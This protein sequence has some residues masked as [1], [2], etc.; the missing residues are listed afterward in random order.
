M[1]ALTALLLVIAAILAGLLLYRTVLPP[2]LVGGT[3]LDQPVKLPALALVNDQGQNT[4]LA[5]SD[6]RMRLIFFG[7]VRCPDVCPTTL[8]GLKATYGGL[9]PEQQKKVQIQF[10][11]VD[12]SF[13]T[14]QVVREYLHKF[15]DRFTGLTGKSST[16]DE[17]AKA[18][19]VANVKPA[20][21]DSHTNHTGMG[22]HS[23]P[24]AA[25][26]SAPTA[27]RIH[28]DEVRVV[29]PAGEFVRVYSNQEALDGTLK[30]DLAGL[31]RQYGS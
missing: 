28:G 25:Q 26:V 22:G 3:A 2:A 15:D 11:T 9:T 5:A 10:I 19:F 30:H 17:A 24:G 16:I 8:A 27:A 20:S 12:P 29:T 7:Y 6:G 4:T 31:I 21:M 13:D 1:K 23:S 18:L 14:P